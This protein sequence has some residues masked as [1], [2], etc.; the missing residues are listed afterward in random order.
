MNQ[1][2]CVTIIFFALPIVVVLLCFLFAARE[3]ERI[4]LVRENSQRIKELLEYNA[5]VKYKHVNPNYFNTMSCVSKRH[6]DALSLDEYF[7][8][9]IDSN[10]NFYRNI[11]DSIFF[12]R[13][14]YNK[15]VSRCNEIKSTATEELC[16]SLNI[17][18]DDFKKIEDTLFNENKLKDPVLYIDIHIR[19]TYVSPQGRNSY[20]KDRHYNNE[21]LKAFFNTAIERRNQKRTTQ[22][23]VSIER[24]KM[25]DSLRYDILKRDNY[26]CKIC[27]ASA[28]DGVKLQVDHIIPVSKGGKTTWNNLQT[29]CERC[30]MGKSNKM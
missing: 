23:Q 20:R 6:L 28:Q 16:E 10:E 25:T 8:S 30:N 1:G 12:N 14:E 24:A 26:R 15:Y 27:G 17:K 29:L 4:A 9:L 2:V 22:Y 21:Q 18:L 3:K 7:I 5:T 13:I 11:I 19:A